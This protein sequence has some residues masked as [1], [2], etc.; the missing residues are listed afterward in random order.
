M[1]ILIF[2]NSDGSIDEIITEKSA[3]VLILQHTGSGVTKN[4]KTT[5]RW[6]SDSIYDLEATFSQTKEDEDEVQQMFTEF[7]IDK[8]VKKRINHMI[9]LTLHQDDDGIK[10]LGYKGL[11]TFPNLESLLKKDLISYGLDESN[12]DQAISLFEYLI[13]DLYKEALKLKFDV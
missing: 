12:Y 13:E 9:M 11:S 1:K 2:K 7:L 5:T 10:T 4:S 8:L 3:E 6:G